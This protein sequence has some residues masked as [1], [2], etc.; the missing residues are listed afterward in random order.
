MLGVLRTRDSQRYL[1]P[2][3]GRRFIDHNAGR[4]PSS[5]MEPLFRAVLVQD[6]DF[7]FSKIDVVTDR[8]VLT[9]LFKLDIDK[10]LSCRA[11]VVGNTIILQRHQADN[12][13][14]IDH[15]K[16]CREDFEKQYFEYRDDCK[17]SKSHHRILTY[18]LGGMKVML[19]FAADGMREAEPTEM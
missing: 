4:C 17:G 16:G 7:D 8:S 13:E 15:F 5:P 3:Q 19:R 11:E 18:D 12:V 9:S 6:P 10:A 2:A 14:V 1:K